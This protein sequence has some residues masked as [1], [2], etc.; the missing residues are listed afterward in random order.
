MGSYSTV[1]RAFF[2]RIETGHFDIGACLDTVDRLG[3]SC[4]LCCGTHTARFDLRSA[5][6]ETVQKVSVREGF[7][8]SLG[9]IS[10]SSAATEFD[11]F[12]GCASGFSAT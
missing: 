8:S 1:Y 12:I 3:H 2:G 7:V 11:R 10:I 6:G 9:T 4:L 5:G